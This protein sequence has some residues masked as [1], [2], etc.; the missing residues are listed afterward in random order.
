MNPMKYLAIVALI[1]LFSACQTKKGNQTIEINNQYSLS[2]PASFS[3]TSQ[4]NQH[5]SL[6][7]QNIFKELYVIVIDEPKSELYEAISTYELSD[8]YESNLIGYSDLI[9]D[10]F[11]AEIEMNY[12]SDFS[13]YK[14]NGLSARLINFTGKVEDLEVYY[15]L[16]I[17]EGENDFYQVLAW[18]LSS[19]ESK[20]KHTLD[21]MIYSFEELN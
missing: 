13:D 20:N 17:I 4:L 19:F 3:K 8:I 14:I 7:Y 11:E 5:A 9:W 16:A 12:S 2:I 10:G 15:S 6:Q 1:F 21:S 18:T